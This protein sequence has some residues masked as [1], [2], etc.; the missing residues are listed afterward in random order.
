MMMAEREKQ[1]SQ[2]MLKTK[3]MREREKR[4]KG[5]KYKKTMIRVRFPDRTEIQAKFLPRESI[6][7]LIDFVKQQIAVDLPFYLF[8]SPPP[9]KLVCFWNKR[10]LFMRCCRMVNPH[11]NSNSWFQLLWCTLHGTNVSVE[12][13]N[14]K[15]HQLLIFAA[16]AQKPQKVSEYLKPEVLAQMQGSRD[17][18]M[19][20]A[21][22]STQATSSSQ[23]PTSSAKP[24]PK[25]STESTADKASKIPK[26]FSM[27]KKK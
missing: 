10:R 26:W 2:T 11:L 22:P 18:E 6:Q 7:H 4:A 1:E 8:I 16:V 12:L 9:T 23:A 21:A 20:D 19:T 13:G 5:L 3:E 27:G 25:S 15:R 14:W 17:V 24:A